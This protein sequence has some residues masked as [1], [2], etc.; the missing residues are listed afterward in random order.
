[1]I[2]MEPSRLA[3]REMGIQRTGILLFPL[4]LL[5]IFPRTLKNLKW[6]SI[7]NPLNDL[8]G[9]LTISA[10]GNGNTADRD[11]AFPA[12]LAFDLSSDAQK[13]KVDLDPESFE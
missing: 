11:F 1:M 5:S 6:I 3:P 4:S 12:K 9:T 2:S 7:P 13:F 10:Q 8:D